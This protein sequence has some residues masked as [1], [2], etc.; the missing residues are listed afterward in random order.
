M[1]IGTMGV[2]KS[3]GLLLHAAGI[4]LREG[5]WPGLVIVSPLQVA[6][7]WQREIPLWL[8][9]KRVALVAGEESK[10]RSALQSDADIYLL[11]YDNLPWLHSVLKG[12][13]TLGSMMVCDESTRVK[14]TR[15]SFQTSPL[16]KRWLR[17]DGGV[18]TNALASHAHEFRYWVNATGTPIPNGLL[19]LW[20]QVWY[21]DGGQRLGNSYTA[22]EDR[23]FRKPVRGGDFA[24]PEPLPGAAED[25]AQR[26]SDITTV[27]RVEDYMSV[28]E[29][30]VIERVVEMPEKAKRAYATMRAKAIAE[31]QEGLATK[32]ITA[33]SAAAKMAKLLQI[34]SGFAYYRD[35]IDD[36]TLLECEEL[37]TAKIDAVE[38]ILE[39]TGEPLVV[40]YY[41]R[42]TL[43]Q[44]RK[45]FKSRLTELDDEGRVQDAWN[46]GKVELLALQ[47]SRGGFGL[48]LQHGGRNIALLTPTYRADDYEQVIARLGPLRQKQSGYNRAVNVFRILASGTIDREVF[49]KV[50]DKIELQDLVVDLLKLA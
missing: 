37:H 18:Q 39:E 48:S 28:D 43:D 30:R 29:A 46:A 2:G 24:K 45:K 26:V 44:L 47:Y 3:G 31:I 25:I 15:A 12:W 7:N 42:A 13:G 21:L 9:D 38:S 49:R 20:G 23:W 10:R 33:L 14:R 27:V 1:L 6:L 50:A 5:R 16:G 8:P 11:T 17:L 19:D 40:V 32:T 41:Y 36:P 4:D 22:F 34:A 35:E